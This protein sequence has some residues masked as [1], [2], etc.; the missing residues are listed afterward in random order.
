MYASESKRPGTPQKSKSFTRLE[1]PRTTPPNR[2]R[3]NTIQHGIIRSPIN[4]D[5]LSPINGDNSAEQDDIFEKDSLIS[6]EEGSF[7]DLT[8]LDSANAIPEDFDE[9]PIELVSLIDRCIASLQCLLN[10]PSLTPLS[11]L[12]SLS[13]Q[14][15]II[16]LR[17][18]KNFLDYFKTSTSS[19]KHTL[20]RIS[21]LSRPSK[22]EFLRRILLYPQDLP[23][24]L[25]SLP[26][27]LA[28]PK[29]NHQSSQ[30]VEMQSNRC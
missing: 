2:S 26:R 19:Q 22:L 12:S 13:V 28:Q 29:K 27:H 16:R 21:K 6:G 20:P 23:I 17:P 10:Q 18:L 3:A 24:K 14:R 30:M 11:D 25:E 7:K 15:F 4:S 1:S 8:E 9:L 5:I